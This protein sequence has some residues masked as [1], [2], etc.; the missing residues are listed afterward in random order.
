MHDA[1]WAAYGDGATDESLAVHTAA[2]E[3]CGYLPL[4]RRPDGV[5]YLGA[6]YHIDYATLLLDLHRRHRA[7]LVLVTHNLELAGRA[8]TRYSLRDGR[9]C[10][11]GP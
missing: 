1:W 2:G 11:V 3:L 7:I 10:P 9:L 5:R 6:T 4:M 8:G